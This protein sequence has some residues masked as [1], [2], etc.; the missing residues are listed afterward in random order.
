MITVAVLIY[1]QALDYNLD[2]F[3]A[4]MLRFNTTVD[5]HVLSIFESNITSQVFHYS[6][7]VCVI[8]SGVFHYRAPRGRNKKYIPLAI[9][10]WWGEK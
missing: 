5:Y 7:C 3:L 9:S 8:V 6:L 2:F 4:I 1:F 10:F